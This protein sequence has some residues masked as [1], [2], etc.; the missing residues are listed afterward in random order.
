M[1]W[2][3]NNLIWLKAKYFLRKKDKAKSEESKNYYDQR[4]NDFL[5]LLYINQISKNLSE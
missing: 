5:D 3:I 4:W 2:I 1:L